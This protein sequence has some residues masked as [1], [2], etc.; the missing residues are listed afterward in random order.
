MVEVG[1]R[2][3]ELVADDVDERPPGV[4]LGVA[5]VLTYDGGEGG[6]RWFQVPV[7]QEFDS[8]LQLR[9]RRNL[10]WDLSPTACDGDQ[11]RDESTCQVGRPSRPLAAASSACGH[12]VRSPHD[13]TDDGVILMTGAPSS[14][15]RL[16]CAYLALSAATAARRS[17]S[18]S[19]SVAVAATRT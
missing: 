2:A 9:R 14:S 10:G 8:A 13:D 19:H 11:D 18:E 3:V 1:N 12:G 17:G 16:Y 15:S 5:R 7:L 6:E 4:R